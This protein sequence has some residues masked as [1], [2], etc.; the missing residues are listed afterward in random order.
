[1]VAKKETNYYKN[2]C[3]NHC[4]EVEYN[5]IYLMYF[6]INFSDIEKVIHVN[7]TM[8]F[9][10]SSM[11]LLNFRLQIHVCLQVFPSDEIQIKFF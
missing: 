5:G 11:Y 10:N 4:T 9:K 2:T 8:I 1:M 7:T 3:K 6:Y